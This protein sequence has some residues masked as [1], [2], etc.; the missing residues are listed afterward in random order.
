MDHHCPWVMNCVGL[1]NLRYFLLFCLYL[2]VGAIYMLITL[3]VVK[4][5]HTA[6]V[7]E[8][9]TFAFVFF[10]DIFLAVVMA[11]FVLWNWWLCVRGESTIEYFKA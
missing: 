4:N 8:K 2:W 10:L 9:S 7:T 11:F 1:E 3:G 6:K 5:S